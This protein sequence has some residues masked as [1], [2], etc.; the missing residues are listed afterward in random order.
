[1]R[2]EEAFGGAEETDFES[3]KLDKL[4]AISRIVLRESWV[5]SSAHRGKFDR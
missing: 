2:V 3:L 5:A 1:M 4:Q